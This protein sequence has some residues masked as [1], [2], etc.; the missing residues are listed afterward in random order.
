M[1]S[2]VPRTWKLCSNQ[3]IQA[4]YD[5]LW[6]EIATQAKNTGIPPTNKPSL[7]TFGGHGSL[8]I[9][10]SA[11]DPAYKNRR[12]YV[13][14]GIGINKVFLNHP[15]KV[16][17]TLIHEI[18]HAFVPEDKHGTEWKRLGNPVAKRRGLTITRLSSLENLGIEWEEFKK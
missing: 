6:E 18:A 2:R 16:T 12:R 7:F 1:K 15:D 3:Q 17:E 5:R 9:C 10:R 11:I 14:L 8:G 4:E 13:S